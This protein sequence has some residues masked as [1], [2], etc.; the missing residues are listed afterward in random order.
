MIKKSKKCLALILSGAAVSSFMG[1]F[2]AVATE[3]IKAK[4]FLPFLIIIKLLFTFYSITPYHI[5][6]LYYYLSKIIY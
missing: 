2:G 3:R 5:L 6:T 1:N 4:H